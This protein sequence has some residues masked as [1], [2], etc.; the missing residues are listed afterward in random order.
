MPKIPFRVKLSN[1][2]T[3]KIE[4]SILDIF[5]DEINTRLGFGLFRI[6]DKI[7]R[8][9]A[10]RIKAAP[11]Y[12]DLISKTQIRAEIGLV[13]GQSKLDNIIKIFVDGIRVDTVPFRRSGKTIKGELVISII[14]EDYADVLNTPSATYTYFSKRYNKEVTIPW[15]EWLLIAGNEILVYNFKVRFGNDLKGSRTGQA[16]MAKD[17]FG[18][19]WH[20]PGQYTGFADDNFV[21]RA[22]DGIEQDLSDILENELA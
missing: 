5:A 1:R 7:K 6:I 9:V 22:L 10:D 17:N 15:L 16:V 21:T 14:R 11:E 2:E 18:A 19:G 8:V 13:D 4:R 12:S 20:V 3:Q